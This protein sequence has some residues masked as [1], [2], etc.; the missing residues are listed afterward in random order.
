[1]QRTTPR[2][3]Q[4][5]TQRINAAHRAMHQVAGLEYNDYIYFMPRR[6]ECDGLQA[7]EDNSGW[8]RYSRCACAGAMISI[9]GGSVR[10]GQMTL[11]QGLSAAGEHVVCQAYYVEDTYAKPQYYDSDFTPQRAFR[12]NG[13]VRASA[14]PPLEPSYTLA[15][16]RFTLRVRLAYP[17]YVRFVLAGGGEEGGDGAASCGS[18]ARQGAP[19][20]QLSGADSEGYRSLTMTIAKVG[21]YRVCHAFF[22]ELAVAPLEEQALLP[23]Y[24]TTLLPYYLTTLP[25]HYLTTSL[26]TTSLPH[27]LTTALLLPYYYL[28]RSRRPSRCRSCRASS[29]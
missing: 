29:T 12:F 23:Y 3:T 22:N 17:G 7:L 2:A 19:G 10:E 24:L 1:M 28:S 26:P 21:V 9:E 20:G 18:E 5:T 11:A 13:V 27:Y 6:E 16:M 15:H 25:P 8:D 4:R 14:V